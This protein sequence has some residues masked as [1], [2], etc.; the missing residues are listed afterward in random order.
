ASELELFMYKEELAKAQR[1]DRAKIEALEAIVKQMPQRGGSLDAIIQRSMEDNLK[2]ITDHTVEQKQVQ[3]KLA[4]AILA[5]LTGKSLP[6]STLLGRDF[7]T[8]GKHAIHQ[9][10]NYDVFLGEYFT[11]E[12]I[13]I[14]VLRHRVDEATAKKT[15]ERFARQALNWSTLRH[16]AILPFY[17]IG[18]TR[19]P[20]VGGGFHL[21]MVSPYLQNRD[22]KGYLK[23]YSQT[24]RRAR[25]QMA[26]DVA[27]GL[28]YMHE[29]AQLELG[30]GIVHSALN[31]YNVLVKDSG[32]AVISGFG[33][34]KV[35][36]DLQESFTGD[37]SEYRYIA[38]EMMLD[39]PHITHGTDIWSWA[40]TALEILTDVPAF[41]ERTRGPRIITLLATL[42]RPKR[43]DHPKI[44]EYGDP[45]ELW[46]IFEKCWDQDPA[47]RPSADAL[48]TRLK[49]LVVQEFG[50]K[51]Q[52][53]TQVPDPQPYGRGPTVAVA[54]RRD[55][56]EYQRVPQ[57]DLGKADLLAVLA[58]AA[59]VHNAPVLPSPSLS[60]PPQPSFEPKAV[61]V[62]SRMSIKEIMKC[63]VDHGCQDVTAGLDPSNCTQIPVVG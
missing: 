15:H 45:D 2:I 10:T 55:P 5:G 7:V 60:P 57:P 51:T 29:A 61:L 63:L 54:G 14:K 42:Q 35:M 8:I 50:E 59:T 9:G 21:Y 18:V 6:P 33:H 48:V 28:Y 11:G 37:N 13:A 52:G 31:I 43:A 46:D 12:K 38:P 32:R 40:M 4:L 30:N 19:S 39:E 3:A 23:K 49:P 58:T 26:L 47:A 17:G 22:A 16:D 53:G 24:P 41:G 20:V 1:R 25:L 56:P 62:S 27:R 44:E 34:S 36:R